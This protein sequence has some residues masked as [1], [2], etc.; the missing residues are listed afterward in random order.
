[1]VELAEGNGDV[2]NLHD[3]L[4]AMREL[5]ESAYKVGALGFIFPPIQNVRWVGNNMDHLSSSA[6]DLNTILV[7][8]PMLHDTLGINA[9]QGH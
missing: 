7:V 2:F 8:H 5:F 3:G 4:S 1:M 9:T 6:I